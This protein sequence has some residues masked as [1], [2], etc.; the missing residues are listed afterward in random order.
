MKNGKDFSCFSIKTTR[1][2]VDV[3][4]STS[5]VYALNM[6]SL[7]AQSSGRLSGE[8]YQDQKWAN[9]LP[10]RGKTPAKMVK[11]HLRFIS[12]CH[13]CLL[14]M[15]GLRVRVL[16]W[17]SH[18]EHVFLVW[19]SDFVSLWLCQSCVTAVFEAWY[20]L[21]VVYTFFQLHET[22]FLSLFSF[23]E[24]SSLWQTKLMSQ[25]SSN[26]FSYHSWWDYFT[27]TARSISSFFKCEHTEKRER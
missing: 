7:S 11:K 26:L 27:S 24:T 12:V 23:C 2:H 15:S 14:L 17:P 9:F 21:S 22:F 16:H 8:D 13:S 6:K 1:C 18:W 19:T 10:D 3:L 20:V 4:Q 5:V 25:P